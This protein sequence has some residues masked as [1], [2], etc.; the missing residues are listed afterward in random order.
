MS[1]SILRPHRRGRILTAALIV[2]A[3]VAAS[4]VATVPAGAAEPTVGARTA[5]DPLFPNVG[6]GGYDVTHYDLDLTYRANDDVSAVATIEATAPTPLSAFSLDFEGMTVESVTVNGAPAQ[7][8]REQDAEATLFKLDITPAAPVS[9]SFTVAVVY[10]GAPVEHIDADGSS[11][12]WVKTS[13]GATALGQPIGAMAWFPQNNATADKATYDISVTAPTTAGGNPLSVASNGELIGKTVDAQAGTTTWDWQQRKPMATELS[14]L[15]IGRF[16]VLES[17][18]TLASGRTLHEWSFVDPTISVNVQN[19]INTR[20]GEIKQIIDWLETKLG[21]YPGNSVGLIVDRVGVEYALETQDRSF[22]DGSVG[23]STLVHEL[24]H[25]WLGNEVTP[26]DWSHIWLNEGAAEFFTAYYRYGVG[27]TQTTP[28][29]DSFSSWSSASDSRWVTPT[30]GFTD[31]AELYDW[32][33]YNRGKYTLGALMTAIGR[34]AFDATYAAWTKAH[35][36]GAADTDDFI[37]LAEQVS[38][39]DLGTFF[40]DWLLDADKPAWPAMWTAAITSDVTAGETLLPGDTAT[41]T[42]K[43][44]NTGRV[45]LAGATVVAD[46]SQLLTQASFPILPKDVARKDS[47]L[48]WSIPTTAPGA[49]A[50]VDI[51]VKVA[52]DAPGGAITI[53]I[54]APQL[55]STLAAAEVVVPIMVPVNLLNINDFHGR[56]DAN[57]VKFAGTVEQLRAEYGDANT[58]FLSAGDNIGASLFASSYF[59]DEPTLD[60]L[61]ALGLKASAVGNHEFDQGIDDLTGRVAGSAD[62]AY[63]GANVYDAASG[64]VLLPEYATFTVSGLTVAVIGAITEETPTLVSPDG[65]KG[66]SFGDPVEAVNRVAAQLTDGEPANGEA[67]IIIAEYHEGASEGEAKSTLEAQIARGGAFASIVNDTSAAVD[68]IFTGHTHMAYPWNAKIPGT[69][70]TRPIVQTGNYG[71]NIGQVVLQVDPVTGSV[72]SYNTN[73]TARTKT[74]DADLVATYPRVAEVKQIVDATLA[75]AAIVG[76]KPVGSVAADITTAFSGGSYVDGVYTGGERDNRAAQS[77]LGNLVAD[78]IRDALADPARGGAEIGVVNPGGLRADLRYAPDGVITYA[79]A[80]AVLPFVNNLWTTTLTGAQFTKVLEEQWQLDDKGQVPSRPYLQ[81]GLSENVFYTYDASAAQGSHITGVW[82]DGQPIDPNRE[83]R[84]GSFNFLLTGGDNF[85]TF[86]SGT[87]TRDSGLVD[88]D[89]WIA[90]LA[91]NPDIEPDFASRSAQVRGLAGSVEAGQ[92]VTLEVSGLDLTSLGSPVNTTIEPAIGDTVYPPVAVT[93]GVARISVATPSDI[94]GPAVLTLT[95]PDSG[96]VIRVP[97]NVRPALPGTGGGVET[98]APESALT[99]ATQNAVQ[100]QGGTNL[101]PGQTVTIHVGEEYA[102]DWVSVWLRSDPV[103]LGWYRVDELGNITVTLPAGVAG[104]HRLIVQDAEGNVI[105]WQQ[106]RIGALPSTGQDGGSILGLSL[107]ALLLV[108]VGVSA[109]TIR[110]RRA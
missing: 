19:T 43:V 79:E 51:E 16:N 67:D 93:D 85:R 104:A 77:T 55:G 70:R 41:L 12:G 11:E 94:V 27:L 63:L 21:P 103:L 105:G 1:D 3:V 33:V 57:T 108:G 86:K 81:L 71:E 2:G 99:P 84:V 90:F 74:A 101:Q 20:R 17:D 39:R 25:Q 89:A 7:F 65:I 48:T 110:R 6:N 72:A 5:G 22:F 47:T 98:P 59:Q 40:Q 34:D 13:D 8:S 53:P 100:I 62:F 14:V 96:T 56:I 109:R 15:S 80:N 26:T 92:S 44:E 88:R 58:L 54:T 35:A 64:E 75:E 24:V 78:S 50:S 61:N 87:Q 106:V 10:S 28:E 4:A 36:G 46:A 95:A 107:M 42:L 68:A 45:D 9:G 66:V 32:Q 30:V 73:L 52:A 31:P 83:Y 82:I 102:G 37:A 29:N 60:V 23:A 91:A 49:T 97:I 18:I 76:N 69:D 38:G